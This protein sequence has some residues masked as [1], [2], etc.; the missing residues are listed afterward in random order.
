[1]R[2]F[3]GLVNQCMKMVT[4]SCNIY[5]SSRK[6]AIRRPI[7]LK[8]K[9]NATNNENVFVCNAAWGDIMSKDVAVTSGVLTKAEMK[10][11]SVSLV[12]FDYLLEKP[13]PTGHS[14]IFSG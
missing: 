1:M 11:V 12:L 3:F 6:I 8:T 9:S 14:Y 5:Q 13:H 2:K 4:C 7:S 10:E